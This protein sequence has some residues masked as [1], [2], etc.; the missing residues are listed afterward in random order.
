[1]RELQFTCLSYDMLFTTGSRARLCAIDLTMVARD[2]QSTCHR[3]ACLPD[4][5]PCRVDYHEYSVVQHVYKPCPSWL[6]GQT[7]F[8]T[9]FRTI[10]HD[11]GWFYCVPLLGRSL[12]PKLQPNLT[13]KRPTGVSVP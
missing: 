5:V 9:Q 8:L 1:M 3:A 11:L 2:S 7:Y 12:S 10:N 13:L 4:G 6:E